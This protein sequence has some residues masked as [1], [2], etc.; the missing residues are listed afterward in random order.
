MPEAS[1]EKATLRRRLR[2]RRRALTREQQ[3]AVARSVA[4]LMSTFTPWRQARRV[5]LYLPADGEVD[6]DPLYRLARN[7]GKTIYLP[8]IQHAD[9]LAFARWDDRAQL[10]ANRYGIPEPPGDAPHCSPDKLD[11]ICMPLVGWDR[12]GR[13]LGMGG[14]FYDRTL[15][16]VAGTA[17]VGLAHAC[18]EV[19]AIPAEDWDI[20]LD[21]VVTG[22]ALLDCRVEGRAD[23]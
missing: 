17:L 7:G 8:V 15:A 13:R 6:T 2:A 11:V 18:Q 16:G 22:A 10:A 12:S 1:I 14:G 21:Y 20:R 19:E 3:A 5:A 23:P 4:G 9:H